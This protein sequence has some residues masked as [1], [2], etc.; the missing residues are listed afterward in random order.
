VLGGVCNW[1]VKFVPKSLGS[2]HPI[3]VLLM[4]KEIRFFQKIGF[5]G[6]NKNGVK[7]KPQKRFKFNIPVCNPVRNVFSRSIFF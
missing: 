6:Q 4:V 7:N 2:V 3:F 1:G 5:L